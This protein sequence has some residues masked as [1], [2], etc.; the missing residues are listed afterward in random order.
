MIGSGG[1]ALVAMVLGTGDRKR[2]D[3][4]FSIMVET[5]ALAGVLFS[6]LG[7]LVMPQVARF[8][9]ATP[10]ML[11]Y[12]V[13]YGR[14]V[15][16]FGTAFMLQQFFQTFFPAA[17]KPE[18]GLRYTLAAGLSNMFLDWLLVAVLH[19]GVAGAAA[20]TGISQCVGGLL[21][22]L[23]FACRNTSLLRF[24][25]TRLEWDPIGKACFNGVS[26]MVSNIAMS[27]VSI[28]Y[29]YQLMRY[30]GEDGVAAYGVIMYVT[31][32]F[33]S[34]FMG[35]AILVAEASSFLLSSAFLVGQRKKY[36]Y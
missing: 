19:L 23:Y 31:F 9:G 35:Y 36:G 26:E 17:E 20:A 33:I 18:L 27:V 24:R 16:S 13:T 21:P 2:A 3:R 32:I 34:V 25:L 8:L 12:C 10:E 29:N 22:L 6:V 4:I 15:V 14:I 28:V 7:I 5:A 30:I 11:P 1:T